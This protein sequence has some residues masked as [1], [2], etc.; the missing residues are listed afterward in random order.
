MITSPPS[1]MGLPSTVVSSVPPLIPARSAG[2]PSTTSTTRN[3][4]ASWRPSASA[5][6]GVISVPD[7]PSQGWLKD[8]CVISVGTT[9]FIVF[10]G[11]AN[12]TP[13]NWPVVEKIA[14]LIPTTCPLRSRSGPPEFPGLIGASVWI[15]SGIE[16]EPDSCAGI[17]LPS[18]LIMPELIEPE[19]PNGLP[20]AATC[21][22][23]RRLDE[24]ASGSAASL[25]AG[26]SST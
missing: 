10:E 13:A 6:P 26:A 9:L 8:P 18:P 21:S 19:S 7:T 2:L 20:I 4:R 1:A 3:P 12:P 16:K 5:I 24:L 25:S 11:T 22:P 15:T 17:S 23:T 14:E